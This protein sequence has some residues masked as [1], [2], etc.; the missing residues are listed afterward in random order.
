MALSKIDADGVTGLQE[1]LTA[2]TTVPSEGGA[3]TT[4]LVQGLAKAYA[5]ID[6]Y[7][8]TTGTTSSFNISSTTDD[9]IGLWDNAFTNNMNSTPYTLAQIGTGGLDSETYVRVLHV[10][11]TAH[12]EPTPSSMLTSGVGLKYV[13][14]LPAIYGYAF[15]SFQVFGD[16]A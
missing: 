12:T 4:N 15:G 10:R 6:A 1:T 7:Q 13:F 14:T 16:L 11:G 3:V 8:A 9:G 2:T 5:T